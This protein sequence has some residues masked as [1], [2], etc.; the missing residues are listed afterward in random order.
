MA[1]RKKPEDPGDGTGPGNAGPAWEY[2]EALGLNRPNAPLTSVD[3]LVRAV[4]KRTHCQTAEAVLRAEDRRDRS[5]SAN[6]TVSRLV[7]E[8]GP[9]AA[10]GK[11]RRNQLADFGDRRGK[12]LQK[13][14]EAEW[15]KWRK[16]AERL[17]QKHPQL[18]LPGKKSELARRVK[19]SLALKD[20][21]ETIRKRI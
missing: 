16:E 13:E 7:K 18:G 8:I 5:L 10:L 9:D 21:I 11:S 6:A 15:G 17:K 2:F 12:A 14:R 1:K 3:E 19:R 20:S 4:E